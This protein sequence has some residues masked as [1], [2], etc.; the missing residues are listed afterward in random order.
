MSDVGRL[1]P[2][3]VKQVIHGQELEQFKQLLLDAKEKNI[4]ISIAGKQH[5][6]GGHTYYKDSIVID[7]T[8]YNKVINVDPKEKLITVQSGATW[9]D[10]QEAINPYG[11]S[12]KTM[13]APNIFTIGGSM[14]VNVHG[15][16]IRFGP[17]IES[18]RSFRLMNANGDILNVSRTENE[19]LFRLVNG[20]YGLFGIILDVDIELTDNVLYKATNEWIDYHDYPEYFKEIVLNNPDIEMHNSRISVA[21]KSFLTEMYVT[22]YSITDEKNLEDFTDLVDEKYVRRN[23]FAFGLSRSSDWGKNFVWFVQKHAFKE[24]KSEFISRN[25]VMRPEVEF[26]NYEG[27][28]DTD[29]LQE[30]FVPVDDFPEFVDRLREILNEHDLNVLNITVR[31]VPKNEEA[32]LSYA[33]EEMFALVF[34]INQGI[35]AKEIEKTGDVIRKIIDLTLEMN[36]SYYLPYYQYPTKEQM[37]EAYPLAD[38]FFQKKREYDP[39]ERFMNQFYE[40]YGK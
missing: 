1:V 24:G 20:G 18:I 37:K 29:I 26:L 27:K 39:D 33:K 4:K 22:N 21:P 12:I 40:V 30:Y 16:D 28:N 23:K 6:Q 2:I 5:S 14:S 35:S 36:G 7:M 31:H 19:E 32:Y 13:Q 34:Y 25:N 11:L 10:V 9:A 8:T 38:E 3:K 15:R 17:L